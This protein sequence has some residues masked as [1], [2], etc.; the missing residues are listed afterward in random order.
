MDSIT[1][2]NFPAQPPNWD[3]VGIFYV[4][5]A[6]IW[7]TIVASGMVFCLWNQHIPALRIRSLPLAFSGLLLLH[8]YWC[9]AQIVYPIGGT[10]PIVIA[11]EVQYFIMGT[12]FPLGLA[13]FHAANLRFLRVAELQ[14]QFESTSPIARIRSGKGARTSLTTWLGQWRA[15]KYDNKIFILLSIGMISMT[16]LTFG[17]WAACAKYHPGWGVPGFEITGESL[18]EQIIDLGRGWEW[19]PSVLW[20]FIWTWM[21]APFLIWRAWGIRDTLGW[22]TQTIGACLSG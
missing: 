16:T 7:T 20:Q 15:V 6:A 22:Q 11:Y 4:T 19:W 14:K 17:M 9:M 1:V 2:Y 10:M 13:L 5:Y 21:V 8:L 18:P 12:W 3:S